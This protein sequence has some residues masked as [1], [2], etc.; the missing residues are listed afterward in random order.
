MELC[1]KMTRKPAVDQQRFQREVYV[2]AGEYEM[3]D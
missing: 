1:L 2:L 3:N